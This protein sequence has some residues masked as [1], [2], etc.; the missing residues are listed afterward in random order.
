MWHK[1]NCL[2][3][4]QL[5]PFSKNKHLILERLFKTK[6]FMP[7]YKEF[8]K[9]NII[10]KIILY[11]FYNIKSTYFLTC[12]VV[13]ALFSQIAIKILQ[14]DKN[15]RNFTRFVWIF[16]NIYLYMYFYL[17]KKKLSNKTNQNVINW[18]FIITQ[19]LLFIQQ[20]KS[21]K[22]LKQNVIFSVN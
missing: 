7:Q 11:A 21:T 6:Q 3:L 4:R 22:Y 15:K 5:L 10:Y 20:I 14:T 12:I 16:T 1:L 2:K 17:Q 8:T 9:K 19:Y 18:E 13:K